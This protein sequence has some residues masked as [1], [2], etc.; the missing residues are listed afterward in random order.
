MD[1]VE[2]RP[3]AVPPWTLS[4]PI[5]IVD[6]HLTLLVN[7]TDL[8]MKKIDLACPKCGVRY[9]SDHLLFECPQFATRKQEL[10][11]R[12][13]SVGLGFNIN[14]ILNPP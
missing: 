11:S 10:I 2:R 5:A 3:A 14:N 7:K 8:R 6:T 1:I 12:I 13:G 9:G 4:P